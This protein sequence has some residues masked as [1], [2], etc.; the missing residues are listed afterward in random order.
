LFA[1][2]NQE[3]FYFNGIAEAVARRSA[4]L[5]CA[6]LSST[7]TAY[8]LSRLATTRIAPL[9]IVRDT[10]KEAHRCVDDLRFFLGD[11]GVSIYH[12]PA[13]N[14]L[15]YQPLSYHNETAAQ[16]I[17]TLYRL[18]TDENPGILVTTVGAL[19]KK[20][21]PREAL[22]D[23]AELVM[24][25][26]EVDRD[27]LID[28]LVQGGYTRTAIVEE[29]GDFCVRG[30]I[31]D[32]FSPLYDHPLRIELF[33]D[34]VDT[35]RH[36]SAASQR[37]LFPV[38]EGVVLP[39]SEVIVP[40]HRRSLI[41]ERIRKNAADHGMSGQKIRRLEEQFLQAG[42]FSG[43]ESVQAL[44][45]ERLDSLLD[46]IPNH[47]TLFLEETG[48]L[49]EAA[50]KLFEQVQRG[51]ERAQQEGAPCSQP[52]TLYDDWERVQKR[53]EQFRPVR[54]TMLPLAVGGTA[55]Q[56]EDAGLSFAVHDNAAL[57]TLL[58]HPDDTR[59]FF[60]P[61]ADWVREMK[62]AGHTTLL[63]C[64]SRGQADRLRSLLRPY[65]LTPEIIDHFPLATL[66]KPVA[67][68]CIGQVSAGFVWPAAGLAVVTE[69]ELFGRKP[70]PAARS[71]QR[72]RAALIRFEDLKAGD[73]VVHVEHGIGRYDGLVKLTLEGIT[74]DFLQIQYHDSD[75]LYLPVDR[76]GMIQKYMGV[77]GVVPALDKMG[78]VSWNKVKA[79][80][81][82][83]VEKIAGDLLKLYAERKVRKGYAYGRPDRYFRDFE[84]GFP[85]EE[86]P[87]QLRVIA[88]VIEDM[89]RT[90][91]MDRLVCGDVGYGKTE[92][93]LR[94]CY[95][96]VMEGR[97]VAVL[98]PTTVLAEQHYAT[99]TKRFA[100]YPVAIECLTRFRTHA[101]QRGIIDRIARGQ[102]DVII[103]THRL[104]QK[105]VRFKELGLFVLDEE[106]RFGVKHKEKLKQLRK[107]VDV[108]ALTATPIP[109]TLHM[110]LI[111][112]RDISILSTPPEHRRPII[113]YLSRF[114]DAVIKEAILKEMERKGQTF[115]I[116]NNIKTIE[117]MAHHV[118][119]MVPEVSVAIAH[120]Q[121]KE[122]A[123]EKVMSRFVAGKVDVLV[124]T[125]IVESGLD[126]PSANTM[127]VNRADRFGLAQM[128][129]LRGRIG[130]GEEQA[131]AYL[132][133][134]DEELVTRD[135]AKRLKVLM[136]HSELG[137]GFQIAMNDL[138]IR[139]GGTLLGASQS[140]HIAAVGYDMFLKLMENTVQ[141]LKGE[142]V[143]QPLE[144]EINI[145]MSTFIPEAYLPD[146]DQRLTAY[147][148][149]T[150]MRNLKEIADFK[151]E[152]LDRYGPLPA[153][154]ANLLMKIMLQV[155]ARNV[156]I[157]RLD[158]TEEN[159]VLTPSKAH[160]PDPSAIL[161]YIREGRAS[162]T[163][164]QTL[165][166]TLSATAA[167]GLRET[168]N[169]LKEMIQHGS[170]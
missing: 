67:L 81:K 103:G 88:D 167:G 60:R 73:L 12:F 138:K 129:Q 65:Q 61:V 37:T 141:E 43:I 169:I 36:F 26:E 101:E 126:I 132:F 159:L 56:P 162:L 139:G 70:K 110:S 123:L 97:Q 59:S 92:I 104:L 154:T 47:G 120:G 134:P 6:G 147:R 40:T 137:S 135:A 94:A 140:G 1:D 166:F 39:A 71:R 3:E 163:R 11:S 54:T 131:Y 95:I 38:E 15:P 93:A 72:T 164:D 48:R 20:T 165:V 127:I 79:R 58:R 74:N 121:L 7:E 117:R 16:R 98:V 22:C 53:L 42:T 27:H 85:F 108:L 77:E 158:L 46:Y 155:L 151:A 102:A 105:D 41:A 57:E 146:I 25:N 170:D 30:G 55:S 32:L 35:L 69:N 82:K 150:R 34:T 148:R 31:L 99:F 91:P 115:F 156:G 144:P 124:C 83:S 89:C 4:M 29:P 5:T 119:N 50:A 106:Q 125:T 19:M 145:P 100:R 168:K 68:I 86:T 122:N 75:R 28:K 24:V 87:D 153:E 14:I 51:F 142:T 49:G 90:T 10:E 107:T 33:G 152:L 2:Q 143:R 9:T 62:G 76:M 21:I 52:E 118:Q 160:Q 13:Y 23:F 112:V 8:L 17:R 109:R 116:H 161:R 111:G 80:I 66:G 136:E 63:V 133:V 44:F 84:A 78:G 128:Y 113:T 149:L 18:A 130:R 114:E 157:Q 96:A 64:S 45:Y